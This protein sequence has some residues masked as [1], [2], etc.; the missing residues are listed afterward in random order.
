MT[1][2]FSPQYSS[3]IFT[4]GANLEGIVIP[5]VC[6]VDQPR[7]EPSLADPVLFS[8]K[9]QDSVIGISSDPNTS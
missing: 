6:K 3:L 4:R 7:S 9:H 8:I 2:T 5:L 1:N